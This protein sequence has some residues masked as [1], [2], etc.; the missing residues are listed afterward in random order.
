MPAWCQATGHELVGIEEED[1]E[2]KVCVKK[3]HE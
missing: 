2:I 1:N 3:T